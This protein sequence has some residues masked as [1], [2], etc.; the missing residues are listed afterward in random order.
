MSALLL[1]VARDVQRAAA[2]PL[3]YV[4]VAGFLAACGGLALGAGGVFDAGRADLAALFEAVP[5]VFAVFLPALAASFWSPAASE[6]AVAAWCAAVC[7]TIAALALTTPL[8]MAIT[9]L[10]APDH[11]AIA[12]GYLGAIVLAGAVLAIANAALAWAGSQP[13]GF[14]G[15]MLI[16]LA[17]TALGA[18]DV[19]HALD[20]WVGPGAARALAEFSLIEHLQ[21]FQ[22]GVIAAPA[23][24][25]FAVVITL[26]LFC[27]HLARAARQAA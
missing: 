1:A 19:S 14:V 7:V 15:A 16:V 6:D 24:V 22:R 10:G 2:A 11:G 12:V 26:G 3:T 18:P 8:W 4:L 13:A 21:P 9:A 23:V 17:L 25:Y 20:A 5:W 27:T